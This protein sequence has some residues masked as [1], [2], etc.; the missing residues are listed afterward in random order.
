MREYLNNTPETEE[1]FGS[2]FAG[3][4]LTRGKLLSWNK[5]TGKKSATHEKKK[6]DFSSHLRGEVIQGLSPVNQKAQGCKWICWDI[7]QEVAA[8]IFCSKLWIYDRTLFPFKSLNGRWHVYK[9]FNEWKDVSEAKKTAKKIEKDLIALGYEVD[10]GHTLPTGWSAKSSGSWIFLPY[11]DNNICYSPKGNPLNISQFIYRYKH[12]EHPLIAGAV[13]MN[14]KQGGRPK[15]MW[16]ACLY[17]HYNKVETT[18]EELNFNLTKPISENALE[19][20]KGVEEYTEEYLNNNFNNYLSEL[21]NDDMPFEKTKEEE[22]PKRKSGLTS[23][24]F[25]E[26]TQKKYPP[27]KWQMYPFISNECVGLGWSLP[28][29]GKTLFTFDLMFHLSQ[30]K[31][32]LHWK[33]NQN[34]KPIP[35]L[36]VEFE[37]SSTQLQSRA[38]EIAEREGYKVNENNFRIAT[39]ADQPRGQYRP[40][41]TEEGRKDIEVSAEQMFEE[42][43]QKPLVVIDNIRFSMGD[44]DE[45]EGKHWIPLVQWCAEMRAKGY[46]ILYLHHATNT[47]EKFSGS[48]YANSNVNFEFMIRK[49]EEAEMH[50]S[51]DLDN[52]TQFIFKFNKMRE[53]AIGAMTPVL[54]VCCKKTHTWFKFPV[55]NTTERAIE[56]LLNQGKSVEAIIDDNKKGFSRANV[57]RVKKK[58][59]V[60]VEKDKSNHY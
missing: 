37:M 26:F 59:E 1:I 41:T 12:R 58:L 56:E 46:S 60:K 42:T 25:N 22:K 8:E 20:A 10:K 47:G 35:V 45:K 48:G 31:D 40:L 53:N 14:Q 21:C 19:N 2:I 54:I 51:Y 57:F 6:I 49:P 38:L 3:D 7:D 27:I 55:L 44:F 15:V 34:E 29:V 32:F 16:N 5:E 23:Y 50:P 9:F 36:Y 18:P 39:L 33:H 24:N 52:Y 28:G 11:A 13:G 4:D 43:G 17:M 30:G